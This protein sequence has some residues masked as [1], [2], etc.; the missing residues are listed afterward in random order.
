MLRK[1]ATYEQQNQLDVALQEIGKIERTLFM[2]D[3]LEIPELRPR[4][5]AGLNTPCPDP[6]YLHIPPRPDHRPQ[7][8]SSA[9]PRLRAQPGDRG[10]RLL[11]H[12][13]HGRSCRSPSP[14]GR[15]G[16]SRATRSHVADRVRAYCVLWL[17]PV[18]TGD[19]FDSPKAAYFAKPNPS[20]K[21]VRADLVARRFAQ[22]GSI[23]IWQI[24][25]RA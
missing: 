19:G 11:E 8:R 6:G 3:W 13:I 4:C 18:G 23:G 10:D 24:P 17:F 15:A 16:A 12:D 21:G 7:S 9:I 20:D 25:A 5:H 1:L 14:R 2:L 22:L